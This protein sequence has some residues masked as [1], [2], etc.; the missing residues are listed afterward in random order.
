MIVMYKKFKYFCNKI[1]FELILIKVIYYF[2]K[3]VQYGL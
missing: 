1:N 3:N 2:K